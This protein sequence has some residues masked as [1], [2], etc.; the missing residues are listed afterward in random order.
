MEIVSAYVHEQ[1]VTFVLQRNSLLMTVVK[2]KHLPNDAMTLAV[3]VAVETYSD[4]IW[5]GL[6]ELN[7]LG[8]TVVSDAA[9]PA[10]VMVVG[11][12]ELIKRHT[13]LWAILQQ[14]DHF[15]RKLPRLLHLLRCLV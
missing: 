6:E 15:I 2:R 13:A 11:R 10:V 9:L 4:N 5:Y 12:N 3:A 1:N 8:E 14:I 7:Q